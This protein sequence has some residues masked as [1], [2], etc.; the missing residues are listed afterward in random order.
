MKREPIVPMESGTVPDLVELAR[1]VAQQRA[2]LDRLREQAAT[3]AVVER[4]KGVVIALTGCSAETAGETLLQR[5]KAARRTLLE[6]C[7]ITLGELA[8]A[9]PARA[10]PG[11][12]PGTG[13]TVWRT[14]SPPPIRRRP[15]PRP[16]TSPTH[17]AVSA[18]PSSTWRRTSTWPAVCST[19][20]VRTWAPTRS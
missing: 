16:T 9:R 10:R 3:S 8:P 11:G 7:W 12:D 18:G 14:V 17:W 4:A 1:V 15:P 20:S 5:A 13:R 2:E 19:T 6:E